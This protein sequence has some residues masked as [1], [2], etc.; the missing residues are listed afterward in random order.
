MKTIFRI[1]VLNDEEYKRGV[2]EAIKSESLVIKKIYAKP[3]DDNIFE[4]IEEADSWCD[5]LKT[6]YP[7]KNFIVAKVQKFEINL[8]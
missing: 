6:L 4:T 3:Y 8:N 2:V 5:E 7:N 1:A